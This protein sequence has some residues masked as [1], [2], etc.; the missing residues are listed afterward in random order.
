MGP[1]KGGRGS[2]Y[3]ANRQKAIDDERNTA[4]HGDDQRAAGAGLRACCA[5]EPAAPARAPDC[6]GK[7]CRCAGDPRACKC[8]AVGSVSDVQRGVWRGSWS[9]SAFNWNSC[10]SRSSTL[11]SRWS[12]AGRKKTRIFAAC[13]ANGASWTI[14]VAVCRKR[15]PS[16]R[17]WQ[18]PPH[19]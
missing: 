7:L 16:C 6:T 15:W 8:G 13:N 19:C 17:S 10:V 14:S 11:T 4:V 2:N 18:E 1:P 5:C 12:G 3:R 9:R